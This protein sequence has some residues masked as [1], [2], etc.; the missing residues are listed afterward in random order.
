[1]GKGRRPITRVSK[2][3]WAGLA[4]ASCR[5]RA[6][7][8]TVASYKVNRPDEGGIV[9]GHSFALFP[10]IEI[11]KH[12]CAHGLHSTRFFPCCCTLCC[13]FWSN[14]RFCR[15]GC[16]SLPPL[17]LSLFLRIVLHRLMIDLWH[18]LSLL[19]KCMK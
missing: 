8:Q 17:P 1:M 19:R 18:S 9:R 12:E 10:G 6:R 16:A 15:T 7:T 5:A 13:L 4:M 14:H 2:V 11:Y 3:R